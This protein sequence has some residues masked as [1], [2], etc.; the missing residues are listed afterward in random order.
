M[1]RFL[2]PLSLIL[3]VAGGCSSTSSTAAAG[4]SS[5]TSVA[6]SPTTSAAPTAAPTAAPVAGGSAT[7]FCGAFQELQSVSEVPSGDLATVG[8]K[9]RAAAADMR[10]FAPADIKQAANAYAD[11]VDSIGRAATGGTLDEA[12][13]SKAMADGMSGD[14]NDI[15]KVALWVS[16]N[17]KL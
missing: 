6:T 1:H 14:A 2:V 9:F 13:I 10:K 15:T 12:G 16:K 5:A 11:V 8:A 7:D 17:C 4:A 3:V